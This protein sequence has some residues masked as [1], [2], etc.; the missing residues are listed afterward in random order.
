MINGN[1]QLK[2]LSWAF[3]SNNVLT[4]ADVIQLATIVDDL[5]HAMK[6]AR[7]GNYDVELNTETACQGGHRTLSNFHAMMIN[8]RISYLFWSIDVSLR[9]EQMRSVP[10]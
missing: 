2:I 3:R 5:P 7:F 10:K 8:N 4:S 9:L 6:F 1:A